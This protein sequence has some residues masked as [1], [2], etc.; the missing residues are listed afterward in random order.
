VTGQAT[1]LTVTV[2]LAVWAPKFEPVKVRLN[3]PAVTAATV[4]D[5]AVMTGIEYENAV[6]AALACE[7]A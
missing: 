2:A 1:A 3:A 7:A 6:D 4:L 5:T